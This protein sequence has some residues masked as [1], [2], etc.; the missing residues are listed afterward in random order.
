MKCRYIIMSGFKTEIERYLHELSG[1]MERLDRDRIDS[2]MD[3]VMTAYENGGRIF[4]FGNGGS[5]STASHIICD[6][7]KG[8]TVNLEKKF[9]F[10][11]LNDSMSTILAIAN[12]FCYEDIFFLQLK[13]RLH[14]DDIVIAIS[15]SGKSKNVIKAVEYAKDRGNTVIGFT[16]YTGGDLMPLADISVHVDINDMQ[17]TE[18]THM[19]ILHLMCQIAAAKL[20]QKMC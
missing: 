3:A 17:K 5:G 14:K 10:V 1:V 18:D 6:F 16:G 11:C 7:N 2:A 13:D 4:I 8:V 12:D 20:G 9:D 15:G 19:I